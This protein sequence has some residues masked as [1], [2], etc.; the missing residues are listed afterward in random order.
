MTGLSRKNERDGK[1]GTIT[2][3]H[4]CINSPDR[5]IFFSPSVIKR[6]IKKCSWNSRAQSL[7]HLGPWGLN[8][9]SCYDIINSFADHR[10]AA[11]GLLDRLR[12]EVKTWQRRIYVGGGV[13][14]YGFL[15]K[16]KSHTGKLFQFC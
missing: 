11:L 4:S 6:D 12:G 14:Y 15:R 3:P 2:K 9:D 13:C 5:I 7:S 1:G 8:S 10:V 16:D